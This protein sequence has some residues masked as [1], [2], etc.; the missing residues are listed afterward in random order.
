MGSILS[1]GRTL[2][3]LALLT[4]LFV[5]LGWTLAGGTGMVLAFIFALGM[6]AMALFRSR[7][8]VLKMHKAQEVTSGQLYD[9]I[10]ELSRRA[11]LP[12]PRVYIMESPQP[13]A[14]ATGSSPKN[15]AVCASTGL[16]ELLTPE[17]VAGV[18]AHELAHI[19]NRDTLTMTVA[20]TFGGAISMLAQFLQFGALFGRRP[21]GQ[22]GMLGTVVAAI[23]AP[24]AA[25]VIQMAVSRSRE[26]E[27]DRVGARIAGNPMWLA[28]ALARIH[29]AVRGGVQM[30]S[31]EHYRGTAHMFIVNPLTGDN[32][33]STHPST[34]NRIAALEELAREMAQEA[35]QGGGMAGQY[36]G[37]A[38]PQMSP[39]QRGSQPR[40]GASITRGGAPWLRR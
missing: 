13:N 15:S 20:A 9:M 31:A 39:Q 24:M 19:K 33:F 5:A 29:Q 17:E 32:I 34:E 14:F 12:M 7:D 35:Q 6:N 16:L 1:Y 30:P 40:S 38:M 22:V 11:E 18:M 10:A 23:V 3:L 36:D 2:L 8:I 21:N 25:S 4:G 27:A 37:G 28:S 26:Y